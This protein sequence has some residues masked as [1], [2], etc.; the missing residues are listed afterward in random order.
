MRTP[1]EQTYRRSDLSRAFEAAFPVMLGYVAI[2][3][4]AGLLGVKAG[5][6]PWMCAL[7]S[8][9]LYT[10]AGQFM[11]PNMLLAGLDVATIIA[12]V[13]FVNTRQ[14]LYSASFARRFQ[15]VSRP[16][17]FVFSA[18]VTDET[19]GV[20]TDRF[21]ND[22]SWDA[23]KATLVNL[24]SMSSWTLSNFVGGLVGSLITVPIHLASFAMTAIFICLLL[25]QPATKRNSVVALATMLG[26]VAFK[27]LKLSSL[28]IL[29]GAIFGIAVG[30]IFFAPQDAELE[31]G[32]GA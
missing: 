6:E 2:G 12:S 7:M 28:A 5:F 15:G 17:A 29:L 4:P 14:L 20:N 13:S 16:L 30:A 8:C 18:T 3:I 27:F 1:G 23:P 19:F 11:M 26:V 24:L 32:E 22:A 21:E 9:T 25:M 31:G 10:G